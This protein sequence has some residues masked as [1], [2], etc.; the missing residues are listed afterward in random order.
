MNLGT[1]RGVGRL[2][3]IGGPLVVNSEESIQIP[4]G[5]CQ[6]PTLSER[7]V[8]LFGPVT[9]YLSD[10]QSIIEAIG[11]TTAAPIRISDGK[12]TYETLDDLVRHRERQIDHL[13]INRNNPWV[14]VTIKNEAEYGLVLLLAFSDIEHDGLRLAIREKVAALL[15]T[16]QRKPT[17]R[18]SEIFLFPR[19]EKPEPA[20][21]VQSFF[22]RHWGQIALV[23]IGMVLTKGCDF[24]LDLIKG[25]ENAPNNAAAAPNAQSTTATGAK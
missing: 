17:A 18:F 22:T 3:Y 24:T 13:E 19:G 23:V 16:H 6:M 14:H 10:I 20:R 11:G 7:P 25:H 2:P 5:A 21:P 15:K 4:S 8:D 12:Y 9:L 1:H